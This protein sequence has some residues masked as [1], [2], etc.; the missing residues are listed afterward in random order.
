MIYF[1]LTKVNK[2]SG[3]P[4]RYQGVIEENG[5]PNWDVSALN[6][7]DRRSEWAMG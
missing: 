5:A 4:L 1:C 6:Q 3:E 7:S 2:W